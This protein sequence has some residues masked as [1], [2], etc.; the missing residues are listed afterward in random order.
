MSNSIL[1][2]LVEQNE[3]PI[4]FIGSGISKRYLKGYP[5]WIEL[6]EVLWKESKL[7][8]DFYAH[9]TKVRDELS[10]GRD[11]QEYILDYEVNI[12][13][14]TEVEK[15]INGLFSNDEISIDGINHKKVYE[16]KLSP[17]KS[18]ICNKFNSYSLLDEMKKEFE[19]FKGMLSKAQ[20]I[21]TTNYDSFIEDSYNQVSNVHVKTYIGQSG[22]L[23][24]QLVLQ[25]CIRYMAVQVRV[26]Q[27]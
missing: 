14:A 16:K 21:L 24:R 20:I 12:R 5:S 25:S 2:Y 15:A 13:V 8:G 27:L 17:L 18:L 6:L 3:F 4:I 10:Q 7:E 26:I 11:V 1:D 19:L 22:F 23:S 9:L